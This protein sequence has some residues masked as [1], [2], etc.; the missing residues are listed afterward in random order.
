MTQQIRNNT[1]RQNGKILGFRFTFS[2]SGA[3]TGRVSE[4]GVPRIVLARH[5]REGVAAQVPPVAGEAR[6]T[7]LAGARLLVVATVQAV[8][9]DALL[10]QLHQRLDVV[11]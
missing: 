11:V 4:V 5:G 7:R 2:G 9:W 1:S 6:V 3:L 10:L 8:A